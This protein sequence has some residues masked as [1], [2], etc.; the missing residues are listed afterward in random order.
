[1]GTSYG[2]I[3]KTTFLFGFVQVFK[4]VIAIIKNKI[5]A[6]L[7][8]PEGMG[9]IGVFNSTTGFIVT[10]AGLGIKQ[11]AVRDVSEAYG[12]KNKPVFSR[13]ICVTNRV[14]LLTGALGC[15]ITLVLSNRL[16]EWTLGDTSYTVSY[17]VLAVVIAFN[18]INESKTA[19]LKGTRQLKSL[20]YSSIL[21][22]IIGL[23]T[24]VPL[25]YFFGIEGIV[26]E[27]FVASILGLLATEYF[28]RKIEYDKVQLSGQETYQEAKPMLK[29]GVALMFVTLL[30]VFVSFVINTYVR[31]Y[32][33][34]QEVGFYNVGATILNS[35][36]GLI[37]TAISTDYYPRIAAVNKNNVKIQE[38]LN[39]QSIVSVILTGPMFVLFMAFLPFWIMFLYSSD[40]LPATNYIKYAIYWSLITVCSNQVD[41]ILVAKFKTKIMTILAIII[42]LFQMLL[43][44]LLYR[45]W[46]LTGLGITFAILGVT[47]MV[48][49]SVVV[50]HLYKIRFNNSFIK[51]GMM[52]MVFAIASSL[53]NEISDIY[54]RIMCAFA[55]LFFSITYSNYVMKKQLNLD[56]ISYIKRKRR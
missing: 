48:V 12:A 32:G 35:Y 52:T 6:I 15:L 42:R 46:G 18:I 28:V 20:A 2:D 19:L 27:L 43:A 39:N 17:C 37:V 56:I 44:L 41:M 34:L 40:F 55:T 54:V 11:S 3:F 14:I 49:M 7:I 31:A 10:A 25:Y 5:V 1:M 29:M 50:Y 33:G 13:I 30:N 38:E 16:S 23:L 24:A 9:L 4:A 51:V 26:P 36:F 47:H 21:G 53:I 45:V 22:S 8:G